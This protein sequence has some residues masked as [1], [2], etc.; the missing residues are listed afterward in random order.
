MTSI[1]LKSPR[2]PAHPP[3]TEGLRFD[4][5]VVGGG[6]TGLVT[7]LLLAEQGYATAVVE[8]R[9]LG[10][11]TTG[12]TT[13]KVSLLQGTRASAIAR[14]HSTRVL[15]EYTEA[16][17]A[18]QQWLA[19]YCAEHEVAVQRE[20]AYTY[21]QTE[22]GAEAVR[23]ELA[24]TR[25]AGLETEFTTDLALPFPQYGA[26]RLAD[27]IQLDA[28]DV[29]DALT[30]DLDAHGVAIFENTRVE[31]LRSRDGD[32]HILRTD[33]G[34]VA[35]DTIVLATGTPILDRGGF[36]AR[37]SAQRSYA[38][39]FAVPQP[40]PRGMYLSADEPVR[41][42][43]YIPSPQ[44]DLLLVGG[45]GHG[46]GRT[47]DARGH[48]EEVLHWTR[49]WFP[50]AE[51]LYRWSAQDYRPSAELPYA[52]PILPG[53]DRILVATGYAKWGLAN[54]VAAAHTL[55]GRIIGKPSPWQSV[56]DTWSPR[57]LAALPTAVRDNGEVALRF[58][59]GWLSALAAPIARLV[60]GA[61]ATPAE[62][63][64]RVERQGRTPCAISTVDGHTRRVSAV[65]PHLGG[66]VAWNDAECSW[67]CPLHGSRFAPDGRVLEGPATRALTPAPGD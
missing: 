34:D 49:T 33:H 1:W 8:A 66:V 54:A 60:T 56:F 48:A 13:G 11:V 10:A 23:T 64:G 27:Q 32:D 28:V 19:A 9:R 17:R 12:N 38:A 59:K 18:G 5:V 7:A 47:D 21:A 30:A 55:R 45:S 16:N 41:S 25:K 20:D 39:A 65:C 24:A 46:V 42:V 50:G 44:G 51:P 22:A 40:P 52:G 29:V 26:V 3:L 67:D 57:E 63:A 4:V 53:H 35:A 58:S 15:R 37:V 61:E 14:R 43:R 2:P 6:L 36:F 31:G 62:G